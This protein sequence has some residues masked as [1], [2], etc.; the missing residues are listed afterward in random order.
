[1]RQAPFLTGRTHT[2]SAIDMLIDDV[3]QIRNGDRPNNPNFAIFITDGKYD[4]YN[5]EL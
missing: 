1:M 4:V 2:K 3:F 5:T